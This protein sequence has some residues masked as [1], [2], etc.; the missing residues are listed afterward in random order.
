[1]STG[2]RELRVWQESVAL[3]GDVIR[4]LKQNIR[5]ETKSV[6]DAIMSTAVAVGT[7]VADA[8]IGACAGNDGTCTG[9]D[10]AV[11]ARRAAPQ[12]L[13]LGVPSRFFP[14]GKPDRILAKLGLDAEG[15]ATSVRIALDA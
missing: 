15:I 11:T 1:M 5:R 2:V 14:H 12:M 8:V 7:H 3:A 13:I 4:A 9:N 6:S 10:G